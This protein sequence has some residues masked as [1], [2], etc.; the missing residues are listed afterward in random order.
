MQIYS[1]PLFLTT[2]FSG[3]SAVYA[4]LTNCAE[5]LSKSCFHNFQKSGHRPWKWIASKAVHS[6]STYDFQ[7]DLW[8]SIRKL[9]SWLSLI[10]IKWPSILQHSFLEVS[11]EFGTKNHRRKSKIYFSIQRSKVND[12]R[13]VAIGID[14]T[15]N[16]A[17]KCNLFTFT[18]RIW[19]RWPLHFRSIYGETD[20]S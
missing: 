7:L 6:I 13:G 1:I 9:T 20:D 3:I 11:N 8:S 4:L 15:N 2:Y 5:T 12:L 14:E 16:F 10:S 17:D 19:V 18:V